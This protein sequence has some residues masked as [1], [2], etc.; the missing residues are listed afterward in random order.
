MLIFQFHHYVKPE[1]I[2][3][4]KEAILEDARASVKEKG[5]VR[6]EVFQD[7]NDPTHFSL[8][9]VYRDQAAREFH[10]QQPW[11]LKFKEIVTTKDLFAR[12]GVGDEFDLL[13]SPVLK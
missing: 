4:Y 12:K 1:Y 3:T 11:F 5:I 8:L 7:K 6:F 13:Y 10:L 2:E 9:E